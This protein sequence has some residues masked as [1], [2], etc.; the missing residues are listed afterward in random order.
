[1]M[2]LIE[3]DELSIKHDDFSGAYAC[4]ERDR[5]RAGAGDFCNEHDAFCTKV[6][7]CC[8]KNDNDGAGAT[9]LQNPSFLM[10]HHF[11]LNIHNPSF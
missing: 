3:K 2:D 6:D 8:T 5:W 10:I 1:M 11:N 4:A 7:G 9:L